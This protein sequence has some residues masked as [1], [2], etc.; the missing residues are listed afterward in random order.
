LQ[1][2]HF[3]PTFEERVPMSSNIIIKAC[4]LTKKYISTVALDSFS[5]EISKGEFVAL[6]GANGA[7][8]STF[9]RIIL[10]LELP[11][12]PPLSGESKLLGQNS[13]ALHPET[14]EKIG[15]ISDDAGPVAWASADDI[16]RFYSTIYKRWDYALYKDFTQK[17]N[18][19]TNKKLKNVS[20]GQK[21]L[22]EFALVLS[23]HPQ[24]LILDEPF[25]G[26]D[27]VNRIV[28]QDLLKKMQAENKLTVLYTT[29]VLDEVNRLADRLVI[30]RSG[31]KVHDQKIDGCGDSVETIFR[32][33]YGM[34]L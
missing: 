28:L 4:V 32:H 22:M 33:H 5:L 17:M 10:G 11:E 9:I 8:K 34:S 14:R 23:Y 12:A 30:I 20:K 25:N 13:K 21:R 15:Y 31:K 24:L 29:H 1:L 27:A 6:L 7:G 2:E 18:L 26:L 3:F 16:A 19:D